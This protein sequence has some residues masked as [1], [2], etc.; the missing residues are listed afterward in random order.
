MSEQNKSKEKFLIFMQTNSYNV[1][2]SVLWNLSAFQRSVD[3]Q[4]SL[5]VKF[6]FPFQ[7]TQ[8]LRHFVFA[9]LLYTVYKRTSL[10]NC[11]QLLFYGGAARCR[12][13]CTTFQV[14]N[15]GQKLEHGSNDNRDIGKQI[16]AECR[17][18]HCVCKAAV[19]PGMQL[20]R[21]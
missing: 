16:M 19:W 3:I 15:A 12:Y 5:G 17:R 21:D 7:Y 14:I 13:Q 6:A 8:E 1:L 18:P 11:C 10:G 4:V 20:H 9:Y 2:V